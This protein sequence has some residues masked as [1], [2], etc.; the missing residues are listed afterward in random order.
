MQISVSISFR[1]V[2]MEEYDDFVEVFVVNKGLSFKVPV[3]ARL[4]RLSVHLEQTSLAFGYVP[5]GE[6]SKGLIRLVN[7]GTPARP[8]TPGPS[9]MWL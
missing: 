3:V 2:Q 5:V 4:P 8:C 1:P 6:V 9:I 7:S